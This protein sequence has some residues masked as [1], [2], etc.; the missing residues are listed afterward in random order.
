M[1]EKTP[2]PPRFYP[3]V[4]FL[5]SI[6][7]MVVL[8]Y[9]V[10]VARWLAWPWRAFG[11]VPIAAGLLVGFTANSQFRRRDTTIVPFEQ[12]STLITVGPYR[13]SRNP[14]Y[15]SM[16]LILVGTWALLGS[17][18]PGLVVLLFVWWISTRFVAKE[19]RHL[20]TQFGPAYLEYKAKVR[21]WL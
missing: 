4:V 18:S 2:T 16:V 12:S 6:V 13:Y 3:P 20:E 7:V 19:E 11:T 21:R 8:Y 9:A 14:L 10:P 1:D 15:L 17:L 5:L